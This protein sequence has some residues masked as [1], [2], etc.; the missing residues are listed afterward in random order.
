MSPPQLRVMAGEM[1]DIFWDLPPWIIYAPG[2]DLGCT[3]Y[4][5]NH[6]DEEK[7][8]ALMGALYR[9]GA[10]LSEE[11]LP[12]YGYTWFKVAAGDF[13]RIYGALRFDETD[14]DLFV[15]LIERE[16]NVATDSVST[17]LVAPAAAGA[18]P[19]SWPGA[20]GTVGADWSAML[21]M[22]MPVMMMAMMVAIARPG[23]EKVVVV[24]TPEEA[25]EILPPEEARRLLPPGRE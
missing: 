19:P 13:I 21:W 9:N 1:G 18:L 6:T 14:A 7:E 24:T 3:I 2:Y 8:Y 23:K 12:V 20:P 25:R 10:L 16:S 4:V 17:R 11:A 5:A 22:M 15:G